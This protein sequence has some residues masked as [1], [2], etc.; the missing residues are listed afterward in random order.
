MAGDFFTLLKANKTTCCSFALPSSCCKE[1]S[2]LEWD[3]CIC[4]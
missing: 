3:V 2:N 4:W 1:Y